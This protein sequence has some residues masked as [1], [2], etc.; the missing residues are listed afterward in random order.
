MSR[1]ELTPEEL[2]RLESLA[3]KATPGGRITRINRDPE[4]GRKEI[5]LKRAFWELGD[6]NEKGLGMIFGPD[7]NDAAF[8]AACDPD[9]IRRLIALARRGLEKHTCQMSHPC[10]ACSI[11]TP[12]ECHC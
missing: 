10:R 3:D 5:V 6:S 2:D 12:G 7:G 1:K 11:T 9:T 8:I 4:I